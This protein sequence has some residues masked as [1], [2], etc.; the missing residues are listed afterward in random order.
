MY[1]LLLTALRRDRLRCCSAPS[2]L[3]SAYRK[4]SNKAPLA[5]GFIIYA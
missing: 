2:A 3:H 4:L 5:E 1:I